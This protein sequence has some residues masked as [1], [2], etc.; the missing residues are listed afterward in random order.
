[1]KDEAGVLAL[2]RPT[3]AH[4]PPA[5]LPIVIYNFLP[6]PPPL[7]YPRLY[8]TPTSTLHPPLLYTHLYSTP[9]STLHPPLLYTH[10]YSTPTS[11]LHPPLFYITTM[12]AIK[13]EHVDFPEGLLPSPEIE[14]PLGFAR[15]EW[16]E[17]TDVITTVIY[18]SIC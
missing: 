4:G 7:L 10:L 14:I 13:Q 12:D 8:F 18:N 5:R 6:H 17:L 15:E 16:E 3:R 9:T 2:S 1:V 11:T